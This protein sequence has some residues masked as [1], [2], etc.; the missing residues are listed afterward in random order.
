MDS[1]HYTNHQVTDELCRKWCNPAPT[2]GSAPNL[3]VA[4]YDKKGKPYYKRA[5]NTQTCEQLNSW[6]GGFESIL[7]CMR[8]EIFNWFL[9]T[10]LFYHT[11][12]VLE[13]MEQKAQ[14]LKMTVM[15]MKVKMKMKMKTTINMKWKTTMMKKI[16]LTNYLLAGHCIYCTI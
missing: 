13:K 15:K 8:P 5:F 14:V 11:R 4:A 9:H 12:H 7:K 2:N 16:V 6:L 10:M 1:Y 3:V